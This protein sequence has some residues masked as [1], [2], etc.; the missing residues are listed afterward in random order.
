MKRFLSIVAVGLV[1]MGCTNE[2]LSD[3]VR[4]ILPDDLLNRFK[5]LGIQINGGNKP[6]NIEGKF[7]FSRVVVA[8]SNFSGANSPGTRYQ[9]TDLTFKKQSII[10]RTLECDI[11]YPDIYTLYAR[12]RPAYITGN[13]KK[14]SVFI[15]LSPY[16]HIF[17]GEIDS[18]GI[19]DLHWAYILTSGSSSTMNA[20]DGY[21]FKDEDGFSEKY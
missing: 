14:F 3:D 21:L 11:Y 15:E 9:N 18:S 6:P 17:S 7:D 20:G 10:D 19:Y 13:G 1:L 16:V 12:D 8:N 2:D 4:N 5:E